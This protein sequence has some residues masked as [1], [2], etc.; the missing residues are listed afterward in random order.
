[1]RPKYNQSAVSNLT[2]SLKV[3]GYIYIWHAP[4]LAALRS[5][6]WSIKRDDALIRVFD[7]VLKHILSSQGSERPFKKP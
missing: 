2:S 7:H 3:K 1:M 4:I 6:N 5:I